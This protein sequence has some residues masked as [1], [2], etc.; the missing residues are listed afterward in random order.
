MKI[1]FEKYVIVFVVVL[2][3]FYSCT[4]KSS[5]PDGSVTTT[6]NKTPDP[7]IEVKDDFT[8]LTK[9]DEER[10]DKSH[11]DMSYFPSNYSLEKA[12]KAPVDLALRIIYSR[13]HK[14]SRTQ[15]FGSDTSL[16]VPYGKLWRLGANETTEIEFL[17]PVTI[18]GK[19]IVPG[20]Y[21]VYAIPNKN[22]W[23]IILN[24][25]LYT[26]GAFNYNPVNDV[27]RAKAIVTPSKFILETFLI[28]F[29][30]T[31]TG[32]NMIFSWDNVV[33]YLPITIL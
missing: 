20:R 16:L 26:F 27:V 17:K 12:L 6:V 33:A 9:A 23:T 25:Q 22:E 3:T 10:E 8:L 1:F 21:C 18:E 13:P 14:G 19:K 2:T 30:K 11:M 4:N 5:K 7:S 29:Q 15:I 24:S 32:C 28:Y 31:N